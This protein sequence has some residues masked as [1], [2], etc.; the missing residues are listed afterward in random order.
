MRECLRAIFGRMGRT[1]A[2]WSRLVSQEMPMTIDGVSPD[3]TMAGDLT[4]FVRETAPELLVP[5]RA[6]MRR[7]HGV[8]PIA[9]AIGTAVI[10]LLVSIR[11]FADPAGAPSN[12]GKADHVCAVVLGLDPSQ[13]S[14]AE[15]VASLSRNLPVEP[16]AL[17][18]IDKGP[19]TTRQ[20]AAVAC[21]EI[22]LDA[23]TVA[24][25]RCVTDLDQSLSAQQMLYR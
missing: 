6:P 10:A 8:I 16:Q 3:T 23:G 17:A 5:D 9:V 13:A 22:G 18:V 4:E 11:A 12:V 25:G 21:A 24:F 14:Y 15:C 19:Q 20:K 1:T 2:L 7:A